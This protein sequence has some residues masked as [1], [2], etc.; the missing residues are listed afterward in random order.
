MGFKDAEAVKL[1]ANHTIFLSQA[2]SPFKGLHKVLEALPAVLRCYPDAK[3]RIPAIT[4]SRI[5]PVK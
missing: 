5:Q 1:F 4:A 3:V 2:T